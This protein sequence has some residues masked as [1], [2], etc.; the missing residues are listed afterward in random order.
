MHQA[1]RL[2]YDIE[3]WCFIGQSIRATTPILEWSEMFS[4]YLAAVEHARQVS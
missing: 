4:G 3:P 2:G 1:M